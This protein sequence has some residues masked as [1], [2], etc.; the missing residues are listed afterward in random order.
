[1][2]KSAYVP[3][4]PARWN[5]MTLDCIVAT[6]TPPPMASRILAIVHTCVYDAWAAY[7]E[8]ALST[9]S[10]GLLRRPENERTEAACAEA[11][12]Y[13]AYKA[14]KEYFLPAL[15]AGKKTLL[16][17]MMQHLGYDPA[18]ATED[19]ATP[20]GL[21]NFMAK[22]VL[23]YRRGDGAN[24][25]QTIKTG[26]PYADYT[27]YLP[28]VPPL[29]SPTTEPF[30]SPE[31]ESKA[32]WQPLH[33]AG[34]PDPQAFVVPHW[35]LVQPFA[36]R[37]GSEFRP[38]AGPED[39]YTPRF[40]SQCEEILGYSADLSDERKAI[41]EYWM[42]G[43]KS[44]SPPGHW[45]VLAQEVAKRDRHDANQDAKMF[46]VLANGVMDAGIACWDCKRA[47]DYVRP[48]TAIRHLF[49][50]VKITA[51][52]GPGRDKEEIM[53]ENWQP[54]QPLDFVTPP[55]P[56]FVSGHSTFSSASAE[57]L[58]RFTGS[59]HFGHQFIFEK[60]TSKI[61]PG[62]SP[63]RDIPLEWHTFSQAAE[64]AGISRLYGGIHFE[65][66]NIRGLELGRKV[67]DKVWQKATRLWEGIG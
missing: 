56:E 14:L 15:P 30:D 61:E 60:E 62:L 12:S 59:D 49:R 41:A 2:P 35:G 67:A 43:P 50:G 66:G 31:G 47:Y 10:G 55:F 45:C 9:R 39:W 8:V 33:I 28:A 57:I 40:K 37:N 54:Y 58:K 18:N 6:G 4:I 29:P 42:D 48:V 63:T 34:K 36:L 64:Q 5:Q 3:T 17:D 32:R 22:I 1:M 38:I 52:N 65:D 16:D 53:G 24:T 51:W 44:V 46:F 7:D 13:A 21:G 26:K 20:A 11:M 23:D 25:W 19:P 27:G